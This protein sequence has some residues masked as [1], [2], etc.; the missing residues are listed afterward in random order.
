MAKD[1]ESLNY[2]YKE[3][4]KK[5]DELNDE[6]I[7]QSNNNSNYDIE[8][9]K[10]KNKLKSIDDKIT[11]NQDKLI[12][13]IKNIPAL[14]IHNRLD[15]VCPVKAAWEL[16]KKLINSRLIIVAERGHSGKK[17]YKTIRKEYARVLK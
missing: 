8:L 6:I 3:S 16:S 15:F 12:E 17:I 13:K 10:E 14:I 4:K 2:E 11:L 5:I 9:L 1:I 7:K